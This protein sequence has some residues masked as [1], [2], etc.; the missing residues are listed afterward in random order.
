[1]N[2]NEKWQEPQQTPDW[3][4]ID[5]PLQYLNDSWKIAV[6]LLDKGRKLYH[7]GKGLGTT[8]D[9]PNGYPGAWLPV[10]LGRRA[11]LVYP[12]DERDIRHNVAMI[13]YL[14]AG[15]KGLPEEFEKNLWIDQINEDGD[16]I[17]HDNTTGSPYIVHFSMYACAAADM[18]RYF[19]I[20]NSEIQNKL[21]KNVSNFIKRTFERFDPENSGFFNVGV[22]K[23]WY[24]RCFWGTHLG[25]PN[26]LPINFDG[27][28]KYI[29]A[30]MVFSILTKR[31]TDIARQFNAPEVNYFEESYQKLINAIEGLAWNDATNYYYIQRDDNSD[32][33]NHSINGLY[34]DSRETDVVPYYASNG[35]EILER[36]KAVG[37]VIHHAIIHDRIFPMPT[38]YPTYVWYSP[39]N[40]NGID[41]GEDCGQLGG[42][43]DTPYYHCV[44]I[45]ER[46]GFQQAV[47]RMIL[48]RAEVIY[49]DHDCMES[50]RLDGTVDHS[51]F[52]NRD[53]YIVSAT[54]H[55]VSVIE[56]LFGV[57]PA[58]NEYQE[59][60]IHPNLPLYRRYRHSTHASDWANRDNRLKIYLG[61]KGRLELVVRYDE[62]DEILT[63][64]TNN[65][66]I[67]GH[68]RL[69]LDFGNR[70]R[71][72]TWGGKPVEIRMEKGMD[73][74]FIC[75]SHQIDGDELQIKLV[76][77]PQKGKGTTPVINPE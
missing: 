18:P 6:K 64:K 76:P 73:S 32:R 9:N 17:C 14:W 40:P 54:A 36:I 10:S 72:A 7:Q 45:L 57:S 20:V 21:F 65:L 70:Y 47:Q 15:E 52:Y 26:H 4:N 74:D 56:G 50:Y 77:H 68:I 38:R 24:S 61:K 42:A 62:D 41:Q 53:E 37:R 5:T 35:C 59:I 75:L 49:R 34:E 33:W 2:A 13:A 12:W 23:D 1:M 39:A 46:L 67:M 11:P 48:R 31:Y 60:N 19:G 44:Q 43:W 71:S 28:S 25:E 3:I 29:P 63:L 66:G 22:G 16:L 51:R 27:T 55:I 69:P 58:K 30:D 8:P